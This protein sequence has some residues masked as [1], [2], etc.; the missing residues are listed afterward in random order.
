[1]PNPIFSKNGLEQPR[2]PLRSTISVRNTSV[3]FKALKLN[4]LRGHGGHGGRQ[5]FG[6]LRGQGGHGGQLHVP[7][8]LLPNE[9]R[10]HSFNILGLTVWICIKDK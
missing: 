4:G 6:G 3:C 5:G 8:N 1:M 10:L 2:R 7:Y 9:L